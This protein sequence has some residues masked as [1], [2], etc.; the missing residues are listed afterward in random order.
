MWVTRRERYKDKPKVWRPR[1]KKQFENFKQVVPKLI[2]QGLSYKQIANKVGINEEVVR[3][4]LHKLGLFSSVLKS[5]QH[6][7]GRLGMKLAKEYFT[8]VG[9]KF[10]ECPHPSLYDL[11]LENNIGVDVKCGNSFCIHAKSIEKMRT[12]SIYLCFSNNKMYK[13]V[14]QE[15][16]NVSTPN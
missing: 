14:L 4:Y 1:N 11:L 8:N 13:L 5:K 3:I 9:M 12:G 15:I 7:L 6:I 2:E 16:K 10:T